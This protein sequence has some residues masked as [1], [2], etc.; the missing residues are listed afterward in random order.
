MK[1]HS[2]WL[3]ENG[4]RVKAVMFF[5]HIMHRCPN[6]ESAWTGGHA[7]PEDIERCVMCGWITENGTTRPRGWIW[8][9]VMP[10]IF[11]RRAMNKRLDQLRA[12]QYKGC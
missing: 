12:I 10:D 3:W 1:S 6:C 4:Y 11:R 2:R 9:W 8:G 5:L 7:N